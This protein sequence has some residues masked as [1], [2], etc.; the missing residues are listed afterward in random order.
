MNHPSREKWDIF[1]MIIA[2]YNS[3]QIP[4]EIAFIPIGESSKY[5]WLTVLNSISDFIFLVD[6]IL[7]FHTT[8]EDPVTGEEIADKAGIAKNYLSFQFWI[9][10][11][12]TIPFDMI[13]NP[14]MKDKAKQLSF[15]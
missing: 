14:I 13:L 4:A 3:I 12:S 7:N 15:L 11:L 5:V 9:D 10:L 8:S 1:I 2:V 6:I